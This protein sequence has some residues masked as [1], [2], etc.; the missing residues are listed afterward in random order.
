[1]ADSVAANP[2]FSDHIVLVICL[3]SV[4]STKMV[5][6]AANSGLFHL[7]SCEDRLEPAL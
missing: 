1:M 3:L 4:H 7:Q 2:T 5:F 6:F